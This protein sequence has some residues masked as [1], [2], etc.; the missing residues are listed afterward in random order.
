MQGR[1]PIGK[2]RNKRVHFRA[3]CEVNTRDDNRSARSRT[4]DF[5]VFS[6]TRRD[7]QV[8]PETRTIRFDPADENAKAAKADVTA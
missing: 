2:V 1:Y 4:A 5:R 7:D 8:N 3:A 6:D